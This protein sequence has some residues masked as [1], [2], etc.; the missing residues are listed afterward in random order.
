VEQIAVTRSIVDALAFCDVIR[1]AYDLDEPVSCKLI[2][3]MLRTQDNDHYLIQAGDTR[4]VARLYQRG[5]HLKREESD[6]RYEMEWLLFLSQQGIRVSVP[7]QRRDG[8]YLGSVSAPEGKRYFTLFSYAEGKPLMATDDDQL[9]LMGQKMAQIHLVSNGFKCDQQ[10]RPMDL[11]YLV[12]EPV[13]RMKQFWAGKQDDRLKLLLRSAEEARVGIMA[14]LE[15]EEETPDSWGPIGGDFHPYNTHITASGLATFFNFD[16]C[17]YGW[18][19]YD[20]AAFLLNA[21]LISQASTLSESFF[22][23][24]YSAR[25][26]SNNEHLAIAPFLTLRRVWLAGTFSSQDGVAGYTFIGPAQIEGQ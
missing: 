2:S 11:E 17:G 15:N 24:Y 18:R 1:S 26:L 14:L 12:D 20:I 21:N 23:G 16:L 19:A 5:A 3:K 9:F 7:I 10:R 25:P 8:H 4:F 13:N 22:A 6:Y